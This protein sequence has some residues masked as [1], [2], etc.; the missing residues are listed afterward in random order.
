MKE[1]S[2]A[3]IEHSNAEDIL[4]DY[5]RE[6]GAAELARAFDER[7]VAS[8]EILAGHQFF[9]RLRQLRKEK[10]SM[11]LSVFDSSLSLI[12]VVG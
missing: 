2:D 4:C 10:E 5:L 11:L 3:E 6:I 7:R 8:M 12:V 9:P 1:D